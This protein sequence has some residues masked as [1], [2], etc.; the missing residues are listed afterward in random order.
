MSMCYCMSGVAIEHCVCFCKA[1]QGYLAGRSIDLYFTFYSFSKMGLTK[2][3]LRYVP[4]AVCNVIGSSNG[5]V[6][7][8]DDVTCA[9][10]ACENLNF[11]NMR[12]LEKVCGFFHSFKG[13]IQCSHFRAI[14]LCVSVRRS[15]PLD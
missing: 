5:A 1:F 8:V 3:Y 12:T 13:F 2:D 4:A 11:Y 9:V 7:C 14:K 10:S 6:Q 15:Q